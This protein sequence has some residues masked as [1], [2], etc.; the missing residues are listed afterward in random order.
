MREE[1]LAGLRDSG[2]L[3][4]YEQLMVFIELSDFLDDWVID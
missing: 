4:M 2:R 3:E 1:I